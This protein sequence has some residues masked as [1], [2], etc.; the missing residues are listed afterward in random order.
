MPPVL[1]STSK[2]LSASPLEGALFVKSWSWLNMTILN[3]LLLTISLSAVALN[4]IDSAPVPVTV[5]AL[6]YAVA[7]EAYEAPDCEAVQPG[8]ETKSAAARFVDRSGFAPFTRI[9]VTPLP[10]VSKSPLI[11][12]S[13]V[14]LATADVI[15]EVSNA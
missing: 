2:R 10:S 15:P 8:A 11:L 13:K 1:P 14:A 9:P 5:K 6:E 4:V 7:V 12:T 3:I